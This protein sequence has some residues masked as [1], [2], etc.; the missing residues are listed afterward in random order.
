MP[1][2]LLF[3]IIYTLLSGFTEFLPVSARPH[4]IIFEYL[5]G[6]AMTDRLVTLA[7]HLGALV[8]VLSVCKNRLQRLTREGRHERSSRRRRNRHV[9]RLAITD[10]RILKTAAIP[11]IFSAL[12]YNR[13]A[14]MVGSMLILGVMLTLNGLMMY[15]PSRFPQGNKDSRSMSGLDSVIIGLG[16]ALGII[17]GLSRVG[18][19]VSFALIRGTN[20]DRVVDMAL[21][22]SIP[23]LAIVLIFDIYAVAISRVSIQFVGMLLYLLMA[24]ISFGCSYLSILVIRF[25]SLKTNYTSF[26]YY[27]WG[28]ALFCFI[29]YLMIS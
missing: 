11:V 16:G 27:S 23:V 22:L 25:L 19:S 13:F 4:Q 12:L 2:H 14:N 6:I 24:G 8:A 9:D 3:K 29:L 18:G 20:R 15:A 28:A 5:T 7:I 1:D 10:L 17:P 21:M 26:A